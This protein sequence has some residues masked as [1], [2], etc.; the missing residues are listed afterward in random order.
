MIARDDDH[1]NTP[2]GKRHQFNLIERGMHLANRRGHA[3]AAG[4]G[5][6]R[7][8]GVLDAS[9]DGIE[10][11]ELAAQP[12]QFLGGHPP[13]AERLDVT[14]K[15]LLGGHSPGRRVGLRKVSFVVQV[16]HDVADGSGT[17]RIAA[18]AGDGTRSYR[19][20]GVDVSFDDVVQNFPAPR[21]HAN[22]L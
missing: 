9:L 4:H 8:R 2:V 20:T 5:G 11:A 14:A 16:G 19:F 13:Q 3:D 22:F 21:R 15:R 7:A 18:A 1:Q 10:P 12:L 17:E 6:Q